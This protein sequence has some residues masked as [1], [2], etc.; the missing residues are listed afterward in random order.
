M[1]R[2]EQRATPR[3]RIEPGSFAYYAL[4]TGIIRDLSL[5][6]V[7]VE[8]NQNSFNVGTEIDL[9]LHLEEERIPLRGTVRRSFPGKGFAVQF[10]TLSSEAR[11]RLETYF[12]RHFGPF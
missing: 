11:R 2:A 1:T 3:Y 7:F 9:E 10:H 6:S 5:A 4:G 12:R 8:D